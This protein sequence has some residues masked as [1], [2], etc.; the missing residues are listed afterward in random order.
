MV[1][2]LLAALLAPNILFVCE[3]RGFW[4]L[5]LVNLLLPLGIYILLLIHVKKLWLTMLWQ[6]ATMTLC[7]FQIVLI[8][9]YGPSPIGVDMFLNVATTNSSE[10]GE[11]LGNLKYSLI[12]IFVLYLPSIAFGVYLWKRS[13][14]IPH[15][16]KAEFHRLSIILISSGLIMGGLCKVM[17][18]RM[19]L[20]RDLFPFNAFGN[21]ALAIQQGL[22]ARNFDSTKVEYKFNAVS[23]RQSDVEE[24]YVVMLGETTRA[25]NWQLLGYNRATTPEL[26]ANKS[27]VG[28]PKTL[29]QSNTTHKIVPMMLSHIDANHFADSILKVKSFIT[30]FKEAGF[31]TWFLSNQ[32]RNGA[33]IDAFGNEADSAVFIRDKKFSALDGELMPLLGNALR[34][35][36]KKKLI[37]L[38][39]HGS[40]Y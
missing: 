27:V 36:H 24:T 33:V 19:H 3:W 32:A 14:S 12:L 6:L 9:M 5:G 1:A 34:S 35:A 2:W 18:P 39:I 38:K 22:S 26:V 15:G 21:F 29:T 10:V 11:L 13:A 31:H 4:P 17:N 16:I 37:V 28:Y 30:A 20:W 40:N 8:F 25:D 23:E 7:A